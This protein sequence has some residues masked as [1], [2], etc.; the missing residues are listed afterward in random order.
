MGIL[1]DKMKRIIAN[2]GNDPF[3]KD[4]NEDKLAER[5]CNRFKLTKHEAKQAALEAGAR[6]ANRYKLRL[7]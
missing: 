1:E 4:I 3:V 5:I 7:P 2:V 6:R